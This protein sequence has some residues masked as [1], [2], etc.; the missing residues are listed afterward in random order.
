MNIITKC[1]L[2][3]LASFKSPRAYT[4]LAPWAF[5]DKCSH[6][7]CN[8]QHFLHS[9]KFSIVFNHEVKLM[10]DTK[11]PY[12]VCVFNYNNPTHKLAI[13]CIVNHNLYNICKP[14]IFYGLFN[15]TLDISSCMN[16]LNKCVDASIAFN[17]TMHL[18]EETSMLMMFCFFISLQPFIIMRQPYFAQ[19]A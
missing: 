6:A 13:A 8:V 7:S 9:I 12:N 16:A 5:C 4:L 14:Y 11:A 3:N 17:K 15:A 18:Q 1:M 10:C 2:E 19:D